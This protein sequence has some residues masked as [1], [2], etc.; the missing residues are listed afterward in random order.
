MK[1]THG[2]SRV[3]VNGL[4]MYYEVR[5]AGRPL[6]LLHGAMSTIK[7]SFGAVLPALARTRQVV[8]IEQQGHG[9]TADVDRPLSY[10]QMAADTAALLNELDIERADLFGYSMGAGIAVE[11][12]LR[13]ADLVGKLVLA[14]LAFNREGLHP[15]IVEVI[16]STRPEDLAG[17]VFERSYARTAP[18]PQDWPALVAKCNRLDREFEGWPPDEIRSIRAPTLLL[19][20]DADIVRPEHAVETFRL[21][22]GGVE[23]ESAGLPHSRLAVL[24]GTTHLTIVERADWLIPMI[25]E[26]LDAAVPETQS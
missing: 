25:L 19:I 4:D 11:L 6:V 3:P 20:G 24:P 13:H 9:H 5:G 22:G 23:G 10:A 18:N 8:A 15:E 16:E 17:S 26:F 14:S 21:L 2:E 1:P 12:A 7:T